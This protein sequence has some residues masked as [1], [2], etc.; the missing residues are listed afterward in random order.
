MGII[1]FLNRNKEWLFSGIG[2][3]LL[4][5][6]LTALRNRIFPVK[7]HAPSATVTFQEGSS[8]PQEKLDQLAPSETAQV[9]KTHTIELSQIASALNK[10][11][12]LQKTDLV[13]HYIGLNVQW[14]TLLWNAE[15]IDDDNVRLVLDFGSANTQ[16]VFCSVR[17]SDYR[18]LG[19]MEK[20]TP[21]TVIGRISEVS[22]SSA[23]LEDVQLFFHGT[24]T[25][26]E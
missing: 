24:S 21:I 12:P 14:E 11:P 5:L 23:T 13:K 6:I 25:T 16:L 4:G 10:A 15:R 26:T 7:N 20:G 17:L 2:V 22:T 18:E 8:P 9:T 1:D 3:V 19:I